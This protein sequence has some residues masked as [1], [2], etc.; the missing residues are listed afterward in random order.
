MEA[1]ISKNVLARSYIEENYDIRKNIVTQWL[2]I[3]KKD[4]DEYYRV[5]DEDANQV[6]YDI[7][8]NVAS[9]YS[10]KN[11]YSLLNIIG[12]NNEFHPFKEY[13]DSLPDWDGADH[14]GDVVSLITPKNITSEEVYSIF[15]K[16]IVGVIST[17][18]EEKENHTCFVIAG[19]QGIGK[20]TFFRNLVPNEL[21]NY[22][23]EEHITAKD[24]D[25]V[26][27]TNS[28]IINMDELD[29]ISRRDGDRIIKLMKSKEYDIR[30][31]Y[32]K[33][34]SKIKR[35]ASL[36]GSF[37]ADSTIMDPHFSQIEVTEIN[38]KKPINHE[39]LYAQA[40]WMLK[41]GFDYKN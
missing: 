17:A 31:P 10:V 27:M 7:N 36:C 30:L 19:P 1:T 28:F 8:V 26:R 16:W 33:Y 12:D 38:Y 15:A 35:R 3:K 40:Y 34:S 22:Y 41:N 4:D 39:Q 25:K 14:I 6:W 2:E 23:K 20:T 18:I 9:N 37:S 24:E 21:N 29:C 32:A 13:F 11:V 5:E